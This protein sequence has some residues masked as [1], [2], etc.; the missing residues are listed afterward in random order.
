MT[1]DASELKK[2]RVS[3]FSTRSTLARRFRERIRKRLQPV[4]WMTNAT[5]L[6]VDDDL[7]IRNDISRLLTRA[8]YS[9]FVAGDTQQA[10]HILDQLTIDLILL[11][12][13][14]PG[15]NG[16]EFCN[17]IA[18][19]PQR[20]VL[21]FSNQTAVD[22][23]VA[24]LRNGAD[25]YLPKP[26]AP[27]ELLARVEA[28]LRRRRVNG[29]AMRVSRQRVGDH[30]V[31]FDQETLTD[32]DGVVASLSR[33]EAL[34]LKRLLH[35]PGDIVTR[36]E[37]VHALRGRENRPFERTIDNIVVRLRRKLESDPANPKWIKTVWGAGYRVSDQVGAKE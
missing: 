33:S 14:L 5:I 1:I 12:V 37:L 3:W 28:L 27:Q 35:R 18:P 8:K 22:D 30:V 4:K 13:L 17:R 20:P 19:N 34:V 11:D 16:I 26:F 15:E 24:G 6:V 36:D 31:D 23:R 7:Q 2:S 32:P 29:D 10:D 9:V 25:D 21:M